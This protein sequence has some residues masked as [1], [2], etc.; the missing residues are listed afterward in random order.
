MATDDELPPAPA[1]L[2]DTPR[3]R[4]AR[5]VRGHLL[6]VH[7][8]TLC[9]LS[10]E[11]DLLGHPFASVV[12]YALTVDGRPI[13]YLADIAAHT[14][15][16]VRDPRASL[17][18]REPGRDGDPQEGWRVTVMGALQRL[19][20]VDE[21]VPA[22]H[23]ARVTRVDRDA[24]ADVDAR[25]RE[26]LPQATRYREIHGF[27]YWLMTTVARVRYIGGFGK[28]FWLDDDAVV[29]DPG[30]D[31]VGAAAAGAIA[32]MNR[33]HVENLREMCAGLHGLR[34]EHVEM[35]ALDR[36]GLTVRTTGPER[37]LRFSFGREVTGAG[38]RAAIIEVLE[39]ARRATTTG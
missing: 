36:A 3:A 10:A 33:D 23:A 15:A 9:T 37:V 29:R 22:A 13:V 17:F 7:D 4:A 5:E 20:A 26:V 1:T 14:K 11:P 38:I 16:L 31:G 27:A 21:D 32:H 2:D 34:P 28:I 35:T 24:L 19:A 8:G 25:Y 6:A 39:R 30:A 12:P 18:V